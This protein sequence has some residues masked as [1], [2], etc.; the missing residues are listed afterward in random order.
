MP[1]KQPTATERGTSLSSATQ[2]PA[3]EFLNKPATA[4][5][6]AALRIGTAAVLICQAFGL[7]RDLALLYGSHGIVQ[8]D[9]YDPET[10]ASSLIPF[11]PRVR[12]FVDVT[13][14][15]GIGE[16]PTLRGVFV[17]YVVS[18][19][20]MGLGWRTRWCA[21]VAWILHLAMNS[22][23]MATIYGVDLFANIA[24][25][26]C[27]VMPVGHAWS[28]DVKAGRASADPSPSARL[29]LRLLQTHL[30]VIYLATG[31]EKAL[32]IQWWTGEVIWR[33]MH[34]APLNLTFDAGWLAHVP[35]FCTL[36]AWGTLFIEIGYCVFVW[37]RLTSK[38]MALATISLHL[39]IA[40]F[41]GLLSFAAMMIVLTGSAWLISPEPRTEPKTG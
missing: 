25:F 32:G 3:L 15:M 35:W 7:A 1:R 10:G 4:K 21:L 26:Y 24:L 36:A 11:V 33:A 40:L 34:Y 12:W 27:F 14:S 38:A 37:P 20:L 28:A 29:A 19:A 18:L 6:L 31:I 13:A 8:W 17:L 5:P 9:V 41:M 30:C 16:E 39:G 22:S 23:A 2:Q